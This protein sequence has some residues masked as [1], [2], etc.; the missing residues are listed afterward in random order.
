MSGRLDDMSVTKSKYDQPH[1]IGVTASYR[2][3]SLTD[4]SMFYSGSS[5]APYDYVYLSNGGTS[6]DLNADGQTQ[7]DLVYVPTDARDAT[8]ILF[9]GYNGTAAQQ[10]AAAAQ[11]AAFDEFI[12]S[13]DCLNDARGTIMKRNACRN[14]WINQIDLSVAQSLAPFGR[15]QNF[16]LRLDV[17]NFGNLLNKNWGKQAFSD[18]NATCG[19]ICSAT[20]LVTHVDNRIATGQPTLP[21][22]TFDPTFKAFDSKNAS[23]NYR[24]Q[25]SLRYSF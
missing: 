2:M 9:T 14:P 23:S 25:L 1:R 11:A 20:P 13:I 21:V 24:M 4:I 12:S 6:G 16:Q 7:N 17:L 19:P 18:Q 8:Q 3:P 5:G 10:A 15:G 22:V